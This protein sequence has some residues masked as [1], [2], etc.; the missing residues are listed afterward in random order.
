MS[1]VLFY[2]D[3]QLEELFLAKIW[4]DL[5]S[6]FL[7]QKLCKSWVWIQ[8]THQQKVPINLL[9]YL[10]YFGSSHQPLFGS[11][12]R[13]GSP[14]WPPAQIICGG[15][16]SGSSPSLGWQNHQIVDQQQVMLAKTSDARLVYQALLTLLNF[17]PSTRSKE[18]CPHALPSE[19]SA[20]SSW[21]QV[22][23]SNTLD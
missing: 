4:K 8:G 7:E 2:L 20:S 16:S 3:I 22:Y 19:Q 11:P 15:L 18:T 10:S 1:Q 5:N 9:A 6:F 13:S 17:T 23:L 12:G 14:G 21:L